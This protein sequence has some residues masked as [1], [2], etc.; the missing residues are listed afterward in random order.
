MGA[1]DASAYDLVTEAW[2]PHSERP[3]HVA[4][5]VIVLPGRAYPIDAPLLFWTGMGLVEDGW[6]VQVVRW[7]RPPINAEFVRGALELALREAPPADHTLIVAKS[8]GTHAAPVAAG[9]DLPAV[10]MT[11]LLSDE[12]VAQAIS[13]YPR[14]QLVVGGSAD[15]LWPADAPRPS[16][17]V[18]HVEGADHG[19]HRGGVRESND[20]HMKVVDRVR[21][22]AKAVG[23]E[24]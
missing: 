19:M 9:L 23:A 24:A 8:L 1:H 6:F 2:P 20:V 22:F 7:Q 18:M 13:A 12:A 3:D 5:R 4:K 21:E 10:W 16:G 14:N 15:P 11:P 17:E